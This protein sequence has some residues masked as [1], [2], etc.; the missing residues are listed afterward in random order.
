MGAIDR[1][2]EDTLAK[3]GEEM[4]RR[5]TAEIAASVGSRSGTL[6]QSREVYTSGSILSLVHPDYER[7]LDMR[8]L[9]GRE[10]KRTRIHNRFVYSTYESIA[11]RLLH[12]VTEEFAA[13]SHI[14]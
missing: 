13:V 14:K 7:F 4:Y 11:Y 2:I 5:Q 6:L 12:G 9:H 10:H 3:A 1:F 8:R